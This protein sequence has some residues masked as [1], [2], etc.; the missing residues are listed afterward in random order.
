[1]TLALASQGPNNDDWSY[2]Q[3]SNLSLVTMTLALASFGTILSACFRP[4]L[5]DGSSTQKRERCY[6]ESGMNGEEAGG[7][8]AAED[9][10]EAEDEKAAEDKEETENK[11]AAEDE[12]DAEDADKLEG[13]ELSAGNKLVEV[14]LPFCIT[15][16]FLGD[17][18]VNLAV[19]LY[20]EC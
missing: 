10:E 15:G 12:E 11:K 6:S 14:G 2:S 16:L 20:C 19:T 5:G 8:K 7:E 1:M 18:E 9:E 3:G 17:V 4:G 13:L